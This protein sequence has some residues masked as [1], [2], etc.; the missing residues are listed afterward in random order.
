[1]LESIFD[2]PL[3]ITGPLIVGSL[4]LFAIGG[5][6]QPKLRIPCFLP[7]SYIAHS[8]V[9]RAAAQSLECEVLNDVLNFDQATNHLPSSGSN[10]SS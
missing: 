10:W 5:F 6:R 3:I 9:L 8:R 2:V 1:M 7:L 4:C